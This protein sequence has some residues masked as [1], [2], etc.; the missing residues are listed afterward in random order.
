M[1]Q[2]AEGGQA[3]DET[4][5]LE[6]TPE[7][8]ARTGQ[9][10]KILDNSYARTNRVTHL[11]RRNGQQCMIQGFGSQFEAK[12]SW[13]LVTKPIHWCLVIIPSIRRKMT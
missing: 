12:Q 10:G 7:E 5:D 1:K 8:S 9:A 2:K 4:R 6:N 11:G 13:I 3:A